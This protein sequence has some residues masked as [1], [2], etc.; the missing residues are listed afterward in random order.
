MH[1]AADAAIRRFAPLTALPI[2][3]QTLS[4]QTGVLG[5]VERACA[6]RASFVHLEMGTGITS[7][8][9]IA[10]TAP[11]L[12]I[13]GTLQGFNYMFRGIAG[14]RTEIMAALARELSDALVLTA[15]GLAVALIAFWGCKHLRSKLED[16]DREMKAAS[17]E[18]LNELGR[19]KR[20][21]N[22]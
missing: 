9:T 6:R 3:S 15:L 20:S 12:G 17:L 2:P 21:T 7:L 4:M 13:V 11:F 19:L 14:Q 22:I 5:A 1:R 10:S 8:A 16:L 18:L